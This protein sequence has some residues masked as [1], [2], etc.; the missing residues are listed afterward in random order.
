MYAR[1]LV[2]TDGSRSSDEAVQHGVSIARAMGSAVVFLHVM[3]T[4]GAWHEGVGNL[5]EALEAMRVQGKVIVDRA[6]KAAIDAGVE[7]VGELVEGR[8]M[9]EIVRRA[10]DFDLVVMGGHGKGLL[11]R[12]F[13]GSTMGSVLR[14]I[15]RPLLVVR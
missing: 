12:F 8:P 1:V 13:G 4:A 3:D 6:E 9:D 14:R 10:R 5:A 11:K 2:P 15:T 7:S